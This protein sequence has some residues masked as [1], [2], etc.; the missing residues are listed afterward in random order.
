M[1]HGV[2]S[3][4]PTGQESKRKSKRG[5]KRKSQKGV[6][7]KEGSRMHIHASPVNNQM[8]LGSAGATQ[9]AQQAMATRRAAAEVRRK[10]TSFA[11]SERDEVVSRVNPRA[12]ADP[13]RRPPA[14]Q[15]D[16]PFRSVFF[17]ASA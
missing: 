16:E 15:D 13:N 5:A 9:G 10:L 6:E 17:S 2:L 4:D 12:E 7:R 14:Q 1:A 11:S 8:A 3:N